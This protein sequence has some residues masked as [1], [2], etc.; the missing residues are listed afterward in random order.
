[1][2][3]RRKISISIITIISIFIIGFLLGTTIFTGY[4]EYSEHSSIP[5]E[6]S[7]PAWEAGKYWTYSFKTPEIDDVIS[8]IVVA[9]DDGRDYLV[10]VAS[11][12][13]AQRHAVLNYNPILGRITMGN[14]SIYEKGIPQPLF[15]FPLKKN[16][17]WTFS[18]FDVDGFNA[19]VISIR[20]VNLPIS[21][22][23][24]LVGIEATAPSGELLLY[25]YDTSAEW[26]RSFA[27]QDSSGTTLLGM[28]LVSYGKDFNGKVYFVRA[29]DLFDEEYI[30]NRGSPDIDFYN[31][32]FD[33]GH[34][35]WGP[36]DYLVYHYDIHTGDSSG[37]TITVTDP[38]SES[39]MKRI[40]GPNTFERTLGTI[41]SESGEW[42]VTV[43]LSGES[44]L[45]LRIAGGIEYIWTV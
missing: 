7:A 40:F 20:S 21:G 19:K 13:D 18:M 31:S 42:K 8:R 3:I 2:N 10:G 35:E 38:A 14:L 43:I 12:L 34:P 36:F 28:T 24:I 22:S 17:Q 33:Q 41:P 5:G 45:R 9:S 16:S 30:S 29:V 6:I 27:F 26:I 39:T 15:S 4:F 25:S 37:G 1:M 11:R 32:F 23:T 44:Y